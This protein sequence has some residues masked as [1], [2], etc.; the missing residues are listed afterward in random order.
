M[1]SITFT[2]EYQIGGFYIEYD[3]GTTKLYGADKERWRE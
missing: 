2:H 1:V 3:H